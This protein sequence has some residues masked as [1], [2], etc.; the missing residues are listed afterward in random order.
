MR[1]RL[2]RSQTYAPARLDLSAYQVP[3]PDNRKK[4]SMTQVQIKP[5]IDTKSSSLCSVFF[6]CHPSGSKKRVQWK[7]KTAS[8]AIIL[9]QSTSYLRF[10]MILLPFT[11]AS[12][13]K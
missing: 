6:K 12:E 4:S 13:N 5:R 10:C 3:T 9:S 8:M 2:T 7:K 11:N 1:S